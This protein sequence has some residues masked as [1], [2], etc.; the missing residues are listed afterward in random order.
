MTGIDGAIV[1]VE[2]K[3]RLRVPGFLQ[4]EALVE[5]RPFAISVEALEDDKARM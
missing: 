4:R 3:Q 2:R 5:R 1:E